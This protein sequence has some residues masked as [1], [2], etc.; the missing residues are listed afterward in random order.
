MANDGLV[1]NNQQ[2]A[3]LSC[4]LK[5]NLKSKQYNTTRQVL[6]L[7]WPIIIFSFLI[8]SKTCSDPKVRVVDYKA[9]KIKK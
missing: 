4:M 7:N 6:I 8:L 2:A 1:L 9:I 5:K 3:A